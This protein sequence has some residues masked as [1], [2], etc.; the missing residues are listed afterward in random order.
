[1]I[2]TRFWG[3]VVFWGVFFFFAGVASL[4]PAAARGAARTGRR[5]RAARARTGQG[6]RGRARGA[7][8]SRGLDAARSG[9]RRA[10]IA[11][12]SRGPRGAVGVGPESLE[13]LPVGWDPAGRPPTGRDGWGLS[14]REKYRGRRAASRPPTFHLPRRLP[15]PE[16]GARGGDKIPG[17]FWGQGGLCLI[18]CAATSPSGPGTLPPTPHSLVSQPHGWPCDAPVGG[19]LPKGPPEEDGTGWSHQTEQ[20]SP[21]G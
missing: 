2:P 11:L 17:S 21:G 3:G 1:M 8:S 16:P 10:C 7:R 5:G 13:P 9:S 15:A 14:L 18:L 6:A 4:Q 19:I 12:C 20:L